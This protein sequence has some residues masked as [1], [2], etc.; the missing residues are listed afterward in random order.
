MPHMSGIPWRTAF[1]AFLAG[2]LFHSLVPSPEEATALGRAGLRRLAAVE[3]THQHPN[4]GH[5]GPRRRTA[6][7]P[8][9]QHRGG[10]GKQHRRN[11]YKGV[12]EQVVERYKPAESRARGTLS[13]CH[14]RLASRGDLPA[15]LDDLGAAVAVEVGVKEGRHARFWLRNS[16]L[17]M[18]HMVDPW[19]HQ[20][21]QQGQREYHDV[22]NRGQRV[23]D[24]SLAAL[25]A[26]L[27]QKAVY[28]SRYT[29][30][31]NFSVDAARG[32]APASVDVVYLDAR[33][34]YEG[35]M[36]DIN[37]WW[38]VLRWGG[39]LAGHDFVPDTDPADMGKPGAPPFPAGVQ[40][41]VFEFARRVGREVQ[42]IA[43]KYEG[44]RLMRDGKPLAV[45][46]KPVLGNVGG[47]KHP[48]TNDGGWIT[49]YF[50]K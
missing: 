32:F 35:V 45:N 23:Q 19:L 49:W 41:A 39:L 20:T 4:Q 6:V 26:A 31:R 7:E 40:R 5:A 44:G 21:P 8:T 43:P 33:H 29:L 50:F 16:R 14:R 17:R 9:R 13:M 15:F 10:S 3:P 47:I 25:T 1:L 27:A 22:S 28:A 36:E 48:A 11:K 37:A 42:T 12:D 24:A 38:P 2:C 18:L 34:E 46:G 30:H